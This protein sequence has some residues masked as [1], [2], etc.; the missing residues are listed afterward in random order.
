MEAG[1]F[2]MAGGCG[3][4]HIDVCPQFGTGFERDSV[5]SPFDK[6]EET[7]YYGM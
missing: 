5:Q 1:L 4:D 3:K 7:Y 2:F 6:A